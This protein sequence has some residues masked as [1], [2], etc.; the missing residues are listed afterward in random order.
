MCSLGS[1]T[2]INQNK[3]GGTYHAKQRLDWAKGRE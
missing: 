3:K 2:N 1:A